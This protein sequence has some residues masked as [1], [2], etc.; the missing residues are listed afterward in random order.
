MRKLTA[1]EVNME[2][3]KGRVAQVVVPQGAVHKAEA[4]I[5]AQ[6]VTC[7]EDKTTC[8]LAQE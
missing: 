7:D 5:S 3:T 2:A 8:G 1:R 4:T 6:L